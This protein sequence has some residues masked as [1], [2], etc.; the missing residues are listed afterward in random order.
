MLIKAGAPVKH[1]WQKAEPARE[2]TAEEDSLT[3]FLEDPESPT[4]SLEPP[5]SPDRLVLNPPDDEDHI[6]RRRR[7]I[8]QTPEQPLVECD[9]LSSTVIETP[10]IAE[11]SH[12]A[13]LLL[14]AFA[15]LLGYLFCRCIKSRRSRPR[16]L[17]YPVGLLGG[18]AD[19]SEVAPN[20]D[21]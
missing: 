5:E 10:A 6:N 1:S 4:L 21:A 2:D 8:A 11:S 17:A 19:V 14:L 20:H 15:L 13:T 3:E 9:K 18:P 12:I 7:L 16:A